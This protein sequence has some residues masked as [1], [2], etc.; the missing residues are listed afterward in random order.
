[1]IDKEI[2]RLESELR[3][4]YSFKIKSSTPSIFVLVDEVIDKLILL[5]NLLLEDNLSERENPSLVFLDFLQDVLGNPQQ[6]QIKD[7]R[8]IIKDEHLSDLLNEVI[9]LLINFKRADRHLHDNDLVTLLRDYR[10][11]LER[12]N[13]YSHAQI[14]KFLFFLQEEVPSKKEQRTLLKF[15]RWYQHL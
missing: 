6:I 2:E 15:L 4:L 11:K 13:S 12:R 8:R 1:M 5:K 10:Q 7:S 9:H 3:L 14:E